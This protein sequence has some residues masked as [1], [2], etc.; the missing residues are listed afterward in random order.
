MATGTC[1]QCGSEIEREFRFCPWCGQAQRLKL[2]AFFA[3]HPDI[4]VVAKTP[5]G[6]KLKI[7]DRALYF[8]GNWDDFP[9]QRLREFHTW[10]G[11]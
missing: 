6:V 9:M 11:R 3:G 10:S 5:I 1:K 7:D 4:E 2:T 8:T